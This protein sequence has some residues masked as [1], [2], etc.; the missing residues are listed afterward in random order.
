MAFISNKSAAKVH[1][2]FHS[3]KYVTLVFAHI[4]KKSYL[5]GVLYFQNKM[6]LVFASNNKH[7]LDEV[8]KILPNEICVIGLAELGFHAEI[9]ET[10]ETLEENSALKAE[11]IWAWIVQQQLTHEV[12]GVFADDTGLEIR[13]LGGAPGVRTARW[14]GED[15]NDASNRQKALQELSGITDREACFR[16]VITL[17]TQQGTQQVEGIVNGRISEA[18]EGNGGF[19]YD[20]V[21][22]PE[23]YEQTFA[24]L[25]T[26]VKN[27]IS[28]RARAMEAMRKDL[29][30]KS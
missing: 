7:K 6:K 14:A 17:I 18:E 1:L 22:I 30:V 23:G 4:T 19:G 5:C 8:R 25:P 21:F 28:H 2:F 12:D 27:S 9:D 29:R 20:P 24:S 11:T 13:A 3:S 10:G 26:E 16:T 15:C